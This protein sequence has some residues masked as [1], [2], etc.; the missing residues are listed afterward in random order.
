[1]DNL[2][3]K[4]P[5]FYRGTDPEDTMEHFLSAMAAEEEEVFSIVCQTAQVVWCDEGMANVEASNDICFVCG[6]P[7]LPTDRIAVDHS[8]V[9]GKYETFFSYVSAKLTIP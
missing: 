1:M 2:H 8:H 7:F 6:D 9:S 4:E 3:P 5:V